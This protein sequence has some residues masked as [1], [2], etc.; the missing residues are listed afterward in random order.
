MLGKIQCE[1]EGWSYEYALSFWLWGDLKW[2]ESQRT[3]T[4]LVI[5]S[6]DEKECNKSRPLMDFSSIRGQSTWALHQPEVGRAKAIS[7]AV[8]HFYD[9]SKK[10]MGASSVLRT[11]APLQS[12][13]V[14]K[15]LM[16]LQEQ[17]Q[18]KSLVQTLWFKHTYLWTWQMNNHIL[19][20]ISS[21]QCFWRVQRSCGGWAERRN[22]KTKFF[23]WFV[24]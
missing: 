15:S 13:H 21:I 8:W 16:Y 19:D 7:P 4:S 2:E 12:L 11:Q 1:D 18:W 5:T 10:F 17:G 14:H 6:V 3:C 24:K 20:E 9:W 22:N 23:S